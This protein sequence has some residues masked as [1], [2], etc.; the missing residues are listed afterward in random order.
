MGLFDRL[1]KAKGEPP[2]ERPLPPP[3]PSVDPRPASVGSSA[4]APFRPTITRGG[5]VNVVGESYYQDA[6]TTLTGGRRSHGVDMLCVAMLVP[7]PTNEYDR[8]AVAVTINGLKIGH[9]SREEA[10]LYR[11]LVD[12]AITVA[13]LASVEARICGGWDHGA[14][15]RGSFGVEL[16]FSDRAPTQDPGHQF[17]EALPQPGADEI[18]LRGSSTLSVSNEE[19]YQ[20]ALL[21][22]TG[23]ADLSTYTHAVLVDLG[24]VAA[25]PHAKKDSGAV[26]EVRAAGRTVGHLTPAMSARLQR[27]V[28]RA[29]DEGK[30]LTCSGRI[31]RAQKDGTH[32][33]E[34]RLSACPH[35]HDEQYVIDPYF[36]LTTDLVCSTKLNTVHRIRERK[37]DGSI[38]TSCGVTISGADAKLIASTKPWVGDVDPETRA[39]IPYDYRCER[40]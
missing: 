3:P 4:S 23:G 8:D 32:I 14:T 33:L 30:R 18:R 9:L 39:I 6:L 12:Q 7:E 40:C 1:K 27:M 36:E 20:D 37:P 17:E 22:A 11:P 13:G 28:T 21:S 2:A 31:F 19:H 5:L 15:D 24:E 25:N 38:R 35:A 29:R 10:L 16:Y 26:L 34:M